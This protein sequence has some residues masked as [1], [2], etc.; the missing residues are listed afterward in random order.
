LQIFVDLTLYST[1]AGRPFKAGRFAHTLRVRLMQEHLGVDVDA[2]WRDDLISK[3]PIYSAALERHL[4]DSDFKTQGEERNATHSGKAH[5]GTLGN[6]TTEADEEG[7]LQLGQ[8]RNLKRAPCSDILDGTDTSI[9]NTTLGANVIPGRLNENFHE[10]NRTSLVVPSPGDGTTLQQH[11]SESQAK[12]QRGNDVSS[13]KNLTKGEKKSTPSSS[14][15][16]VHKADSEGQVS[17]VVPAQALTTND[18]LR[19]SPPGLSNSLEADEK[20]L[21]PTLRKI[22]TNVKALTE[23]QSAFPKSSHTNKTWKLPPPPDVDPCGFED[24]ISDKFWRNVWVACAMHNVSL[25]WK[26]VL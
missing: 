7:S 9:I 11:Q 26:W 1:M 4:P 3:E 21:H 14:T 12:N 22:D 25:E 13:T 10:C 2:L 18:F 23:A 15:E 20:L 5:Q 6:T 24:P 17:N 19:D 16:N 8:S